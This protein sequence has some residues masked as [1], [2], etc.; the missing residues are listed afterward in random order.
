VKKHIPVLKKESIDLLNIKKGGT[1]ID[2]TLGEGGHAT[3]IINNLGKGNLIALD[4]D[5]KHVDDFVKETSEI[6]DVHIYA[7]NANFSNLERIVDSLKDEGVTKVDGILFDLGWAS[8]QLERMEGLSYMSK[9]DELDMRLDMSFGVKA[10]DLLNGLGSKELEKMF[11]DYADIQGSILKKLSEAIKIER[12]RKM[13][14]K[15]D[16]LNKLIDKTFRFDPVREKSKRMSFLS[17]VYQALRIAVNNEMYNLKLALED[18]KKVL[19]PGGRVVIITFHSGE[20]NLVKDYFK[21]SAADKFKEVA[22]EVRPT[23]DEL[24]ANLSSRSA[25]LYCY[26]YQG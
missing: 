13:F 5:Q 17:K 9:D 25:K 11:S 2:C 20:E 21:R 15:V 4:V 3:E 12:K 18:L 22:F 14:S 8:D 16:D 23:V 19:N 10:S 1:Y 24:L 6:G 26:E 7:R